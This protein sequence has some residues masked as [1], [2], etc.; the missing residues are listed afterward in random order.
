MQF[1]YHRTPQVF[2]GAMRRK[3]CG[4]DVIEFN[5]TVIRIAVKVD[6]S[7]YTP[8]TYLDYSWC[9]RS[10]DQF[11]PFRCRGEKLRNM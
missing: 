10:W 6:K 5:L 11:P 3:C 1:R 8:Y 2:V 9:W 4:E 7:A